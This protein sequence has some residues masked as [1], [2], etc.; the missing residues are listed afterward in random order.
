MKNGVIGETAL[1]TG[2][3]GFVGSALVR[4]LLDA[5]V[6]VIVYDNFQ[7][8]TK[9]N[10]E[11]VE[12]EIEIVIGDILDEWKL[13]ETF[14]KYKP[15]YVFH[16]VG[17]TFVP[18]AY[19][20]PKRFLRI[21]AEGTLNVLMACKYFP[22]ERM[23]YVSSTEVFGE[24]PTLPMNENHPLNHLNT[25]AVTKMT[26]DRLCYT[27]Y[28]EHGVPVLIARIFNSYGP[29]ETHPYVIP[30]IISQFH[31]GNV[32]ELGNLD[33]RR[34]FTYV[35]DTAKGLIAAMTSDIPN[36]EV[37]NIGSGVS[38]SV[39]DL[40]AIIAGIMGIKEYEIQI[41]EKRLRRYDIQ[42]F[43]CDYSK[44]HEATGWK[45]EIDI[46]TGLELTID[47]FR[48]HGCKWGWEDLLEGT[49]YEV[50]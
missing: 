32:L 3:A 29:I 22:V 31:K 6:D 47:W 11:E 26:A 2:G 14:S 21:N 41:D 50:I 1:V 39:K 9:R 24:N 17:D 4:E 43:R 45:P 16:L 48:S 49:I 42:E 13:V 8:G 40:V 10:L 25:Y 20:M 30:E 23:L 37:V 12:W 36:G 5:G 28:H 19:M 46:T 27:F 33:A 38:Y 18:T 7:A 34:D 15:D 44:L 35:H